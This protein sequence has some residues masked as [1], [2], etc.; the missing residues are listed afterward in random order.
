MTEDTFI[1]PPHLADLSQQLHSAAARGDNVLLVGDPGCTIALL[2]RALTD[3]ITTT[4][5][6]LSENATICRMANCE[7]PADMIPFRAPHHTCSLAGLIGGGK[8]WRPGEVSLAHGG[9]LYLEEIG[10]HSRR[11][12]ERLQ[13]AIAHKF[14]EDRTGGWRVPAEFLLVATVTLKMRGRIPDG[15][16]GLTLDIPNL[17]EPVG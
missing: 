6:R 17:P 10:E 12:L 7:P 16:F 15:I 11:N 8:P 5:S 4:A 3:E 14:V 9:I 2:A 13:H 1:V